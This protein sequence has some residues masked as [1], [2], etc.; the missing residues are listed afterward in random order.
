[1]KAANGGIRAAGIDF[2]SNHPRTNEPRVRA[3]VTFP[4]SLPPSRVELAKGRTVAITS[5]ALS[6]DS[7]TETRASSLS[8]SRRLLDATDV[9][10]RDAADA[11]GA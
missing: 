10:R 6:A 5:G 7:A 8:S 9:A 2:P 3:R 4:P 11:S 1:M